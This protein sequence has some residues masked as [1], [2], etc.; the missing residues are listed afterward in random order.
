MGISGVASSDEEKLIKRACLA[1][2]NSYSPYSHFQVGA[3]LLAENKKGSRKIFLGTN[4]ETVTYNTNCAE[5]SAIYGALSN[6][7][8]KMIEMVIV[9]DTE[10][11]TP[12][13]G[14]C[15]QVLIEFCPD[16]PILLAHIFDDELETVY[17]HELL[18][19]AFTPEILK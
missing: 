2:K 7:F 14:V 8:R 15:R 11:F 5:R 13:C 12:P 3:A 4:V 16:L 19:M 10:V 17:P 9:T 6:G 1:W 18:P